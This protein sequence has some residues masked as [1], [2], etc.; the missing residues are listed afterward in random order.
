MDDEEYRE[1]ALA[2]SEQ[3]TDAINTNTEALVFHRHEVQLLRTTIEAMV[4][5]MEHLNERL[6][7]LAE[8]TK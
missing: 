5:I 4:L 8:A 2:A 1:A 7:A 3:R 6:R